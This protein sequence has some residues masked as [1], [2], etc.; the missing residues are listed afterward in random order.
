MFNPGIWTQKP[1]AGDMAVSGLKRIGAFNLEVARFMADRA[2]K[3]AVLVAS[4]SMCRSTQDAVAT[5]REAAI[6]AVDDYASEVER[7]MDNQAP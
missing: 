1:A 4:L 7:L 5:W 3:N 2:R 6:E